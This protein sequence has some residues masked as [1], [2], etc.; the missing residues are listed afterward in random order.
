MTGRRSSQTSLREANSRRVLDVLRAGRATQAEIARATDLSGA[1][2]S[3]IVRDLLSAGAVEAVDHAG[4]GQLVQLSA[5]SG[6]TAG[7]AF[8]S[9]RALLA[10][11]DL[12]STV[13]AERIVP[14]PAALSADEALAA[15]L[16]ALDELLAAEGVDGQAL[17]AVGVSLA[18]PLV[19]GSSVA[20]HTRWAGYDLE[21][22]L[23]RLLPCPVHIDNDANLG[24][25]A[26]SRWGELAGH[27]VGAWVKASTGI[28][29]GVVLDGRVHRGAKGL[30]GE[31]GHVQTHP[32]GQLC[33]CGNRGCLE[34]TAGTPALVREYAAITG[35]SVT[36]LELVAAAVA[37]DVVARRIVDDAGTRIGTALAG[38]VTLIDPE[39][40]VVGGDLA[41]AG[42]LLLDPL[43]AAMRRG[44]MPA[45]ADDVSV[46]VSSLG[47][48]AEVLGALA[49]ALD[50]AIPQVT[51]S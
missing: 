35:R 18:T 1:T 41:V 21:A 15:A 33:G 7:I 17:A 12:T 32:D 3:T 31:L 28:G 45:V 43:V 14:L 5:R 24:A 16:Q 25:R 36:A 29:V 6:L 51:G 23:H 8:G 2:V 48:R 22:A 10:L 47:E 4:R 42:D 13:R 39:R 30:A 27:R 44:A 11:G 34:L 46:A 49:L 37:G 26:E 19:A 20:H 50:H 40:V 38:L 9:T